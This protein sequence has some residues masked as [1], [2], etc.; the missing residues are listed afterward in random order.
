MKFIEGVKYI[1]QELE[2][3]YPILVGVDHHYDRRIQGGV[4]YNAP[5]YTT[6]HFIV[7]VGRDSDANGF[8]YRFYEVGTGKYA[9]QGSKVNLELLNNTYRP[10]GIH[11][12]NKLYVKNNIL[13]GKTK[14]KPDCSYVVTEVRRNQ[15]K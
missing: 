3:G 10:N 12:D 11:D 8:F 1:D 13:I 14:Y 6:D 2:A 15:H 4:R 5:N 9:F 7:I